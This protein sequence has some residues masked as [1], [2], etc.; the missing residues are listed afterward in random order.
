LKEEIVQNITATL[1]VQTE[2]DI[3]L[4]K[5]AKLK[6][7]IKEMKKQSQDRENSLTQEIRGLK[8]ETNE[9]EKKSQDQP[10]ATQIGSRAKFMLK[11]HAEGQNIDFSTDLVVFSIK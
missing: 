8:Q 7:E 2:E 1:L 4:D 3:K 11:C 5:I 6:Q 10:W 9:L